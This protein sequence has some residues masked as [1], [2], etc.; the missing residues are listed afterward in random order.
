[1]L[2]SVAQLGGAD[3]WAGLNAVLTK[4]VC[5]A[6]ALHLSLHFTDFILHPP[7]WILFLAGAC[8]VVF[9]WKRFENVRSAL[10]GR[11]DGD[12]IVRKI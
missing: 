12:V 8:P 10:I 1:M 3:R 5:H 11:F 2:F 6:A 7:D 9:R 4:E